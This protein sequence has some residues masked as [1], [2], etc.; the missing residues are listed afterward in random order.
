VPDDVKPLFH[1]YVEAQVEERAREI[2]D[3]YRE[4]VEGW[5]KEVRSGSGD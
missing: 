4:M 3:R 5:K 2:L 1:V